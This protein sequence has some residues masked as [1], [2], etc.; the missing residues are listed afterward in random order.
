VAPR[1]S[2]AL[3]LCVCCHM[4]E[5]QNKTAKEGEKAKSEERQKN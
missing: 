3:S 1:E 2:P 5:K 4:K